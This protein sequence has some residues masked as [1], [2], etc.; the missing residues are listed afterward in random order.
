[1]DTGDDEIIMNEPG[2]VI[3]MTEELF[4]QEFGFNP[5]ELSSDMDSSDHEAVDGFV[6]PAEQTTDPTGEFVEMSD[7][8]V[9]ILIDDSE[10]SSTMKKTLCDIN[11]L[12]RFL[13]LK[14][15]SREIYQIDVDTLDSYLANFIL[16]VRKPNGSE[17]EPSTIRN[18][19]SSFDRYLKRKRYQHKIANGYTNGFS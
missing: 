3:E 10:N 8:D 9:Q 6:F 16:S 5:H 4:T 15:E 11:K 12:K 17:Y 1:M 19:V 7:T 2:N 14:G 13:Q 18:M